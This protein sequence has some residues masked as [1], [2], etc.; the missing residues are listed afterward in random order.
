MMI[1]KQIALV[2]REPTGMADPI[3]DEVLE[4]LHKRGQESL[5]NADRLVR[6]SFL[7][8]VTY[9]DIGNPA[10]KL[11]G[12][13]ERLKP[14]LVVCLHVHVLTSYWKLFQAACYVI[15]FIDFK[16]DSEYLCFWGLIL[17]IHRPTSSLHST[18]FSMVKDLVINHVRST[19]C[20]QLDIRSSN[21][22]YRQYIA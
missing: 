8:P 11:I 7:K 5:L 3:P 21:I 22:H 6:K 12:L 14:Q 19:M 16:I 18:H 4:S 15:Y 1:L 2:V 10:E 9:I 17:S 13:A 20:L